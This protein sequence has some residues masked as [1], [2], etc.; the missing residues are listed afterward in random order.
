MK[1]TQINIDLFDYHEKQLI[2][3]LDS[4]FE[5]DLSCEYSETDKYVTDS[6]YCTLGDLRFA[7]FDKEEFLSMHMPNIGHH[8]L[9][10]KRN[11]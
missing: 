4:V 11:R 10:P 9:P 1:P 6:E 5:K 8:I 2:R 7:N 3:Q